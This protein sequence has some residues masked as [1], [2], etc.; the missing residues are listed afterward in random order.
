MIDEKTK[1]EDPSGNSGTAYAYASLDEYLL[2]E[3]RHY[4]I[5][6]SGGNTSGC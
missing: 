1:G 4:L 2:D 6:V 5:Q 3:H